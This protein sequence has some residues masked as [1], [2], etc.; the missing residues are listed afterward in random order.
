MPRKDVLDAVR[1][2]TDPFRVTKG[3]G[4]CHIKRFYW[5][6]LTPRREPG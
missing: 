4:H 2:Y 5:S 1:K 3:K 6:I